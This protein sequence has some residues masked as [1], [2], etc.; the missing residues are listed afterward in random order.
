MPEFRSAS[1][2][3]RYDILCR[4]L[5]QENLYTQAVLVTSTRDLGVEGH[6][7]ALNETTSLHVFAAT[8]AGHVAAS[9]AT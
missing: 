5:R 2:L 3:E 7:G 9:A 1:Y 4:K 6:H 8:L